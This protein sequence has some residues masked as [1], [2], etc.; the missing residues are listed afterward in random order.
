MYSSVCGNRL[1]TFKIL[2]STEKTYLNL[3]VSFIG[4]TYA[5]GDT[6]FRRRRK[7]EFFLKLCVYPHEAFLLRE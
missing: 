7:T 2:F 5:K 6:E 3:C 4:T 1:G